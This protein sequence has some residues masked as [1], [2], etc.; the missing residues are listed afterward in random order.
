MSTGYDAMWV[1]RTDPDDDF[2]PPVVSGAGD[3]PGIP[4]A[5]NPAA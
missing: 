2:W 4:A 5:G 3:H 1:S